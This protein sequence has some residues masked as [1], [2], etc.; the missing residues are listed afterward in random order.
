MS[1]SSDEELEL[2]N[3]EL[4]LR[5]KTK[6]ESPAAPKGSP[7]TDM[8]K[9]VVQATPGIGQAVGMSDALSKLPPEGQRAVTTAAGAELGLP[10]GAL[11]SGAVAATAGGLTEAAQNPKAAVK[12]VAPVTQ[13]IMAPTAENVLNTITSLTTPKAK[14]FAKRRA[15][16]F[17]TAAASG[18]ALK[19]LRGVTASG[20]ISAGVE[21]PALVSG[22]VRNRILNE[23]GVAKGQAMSG[24]NLVEGQRLMK[25]L[26]SPAGQGRLADEAI[27]AVEE[28]KK[29]SNTQLL[30]Y[31]EALGKVQ[32]KG[33]TFS[34]VYQKGRNLIRAQLKEQAP[35]LFAKK[36]AA[37]KV[38]QSMGKGEGNVSLVEAIR[39]PISSAVH[40]PGAQR[41]LGAGTRIGSEAI[42]PAFVSSANLLSSSLEKLGK[43]RKR[44]KGE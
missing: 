7:I 29:L 13:A 21:N 14:E 2:I 33:G 42:F 31:E 12:A 25:M 27:K 11:A 17:G 8:A 10:M 18:A 4:A 30:A 36:A 6:A 16:E 20:P 39:H 32:T 22:G 3:I 23:L 24:E 1:L 38:F 43:S 5:E 40:F 9:Q 44:A 15:I 34:D 35:T 26:R 41:L 28:G 19:A 37:R